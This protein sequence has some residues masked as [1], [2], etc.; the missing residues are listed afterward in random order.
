MKWTGCQER[1]VR[2]SKT[3]RKEELKRKKGGNGVNG[4]KRKEEVNERVG[5]IETKGM[6]VTK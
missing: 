2:K 4:L 6:E 3:N 5:N 1:K